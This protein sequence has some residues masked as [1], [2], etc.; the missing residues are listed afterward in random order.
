MSNQTAE[1]NVSE[2][3]A[4][5][6]VAIANWAHSVGARDLNQLDAPWEGETSRYKIRI[7]GASEER[8]AIPPFGMVVTLDDCICPVAMLTPSSGIVLSGD[9]GTVES[10]AGLIAHFEAETRKQV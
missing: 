5:L 3:I 6:A 10:E 7:N 4:R 1:R 2:G 8:E 9:A